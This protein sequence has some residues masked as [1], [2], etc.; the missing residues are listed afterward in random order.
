MKSQPK[1]AVKNVAVIFGDHTKPDKVKPSEVFDED[2]FYTIDRLKEALQT[3]GGYKFTHLTDHDT[4]IDDLRKLRGKFDYALNFCDEGY[5]NDP[6]KELHVPAL[7]EILDIPY[8]GA[9]PQCLAHCYDKSLVRG[10][11]KEMDMP[12]PAGIFLDPKQTAFS[13][14]FGFPAFVKPNF[15]DS[16]YGITRKSIVNNGDELIDAILDVIESFGYEKEILVEEYLTGKDITVGVIGNPPNAHIVLPITEED[17]STLPPNLPKICGYEAKW[18]P[19]SPYWNIK[20]RPAQLPAETEEY[21]VECCLRLFQRLGCRDYARFDWR[22]DSE[23]NPKLLE[24]NPN[25]GWCWDGHLAKMAK[26]AGMEYSDMLAAIL[27][28]AELRLGVK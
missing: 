20:S 3:L 5:N 15:G 8:T 17:Y 12:V 18:L 24:V 6:H 14:P 19:D 16:S 2:D 25:P 4:L 13:L 27:K 10:A 23:R 28:S 1:S 26:I 11:A 22:L 9:G 21:V 7:L